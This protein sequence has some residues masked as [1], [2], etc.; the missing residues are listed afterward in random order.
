MK[1]KF[2][3]DEEIINMYLIRDEKAIEKT[4]GKYG[5]YVRTI[6]YNILN[7]APESDECKSDT[8]MG[9]WKSIPPKRPRV[10]KAY[11]AKIARGVALNRYKARMRDKRVISEYTVSM[12][13]FDGM[14]SDIGDT[15]EEEILAR[16]LGRAISSFIRELPEE[17]RLIFISRYYFSDPVKVIA[18][19]VGVTSSAI[20]KQL[21]AMRE[22]LAEYLTKEGFE[23]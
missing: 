7:D 15:V 18:R 16:E 17:R 8:Y 9:L 23:L 6:A 11:I 5:G 2:I 4:D 20:F 22:S 1:S 12:S 21:A 3:S 13:D 19:R 14:I 10:F